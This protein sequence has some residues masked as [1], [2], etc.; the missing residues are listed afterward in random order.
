MAV[1]RLARRLRAERTDTSLS[2]SQIAALGTLARLGPMT[3]GEL[4]DVEKVQ[5]PSMTRTVAGARGS[6]PRPACPAPCRPASGAA[7]SDRGGRPDAA[8]RPPPPGRLAVSAHVGAHAGRPRQA[9]RRRRGPRTV[10]QLLSPTFSALRIRNYRLY[11]TGALISN[12]GTWMQR[13]AQ[14]WLVL[15]LTH[16]S[17]AALGITTGLQFLPI[18]LVTPFAGVVVDRVSKRKLL[19]VTQGFLGLTA[20]VARA[21]ST[22]PASSPSARSTSSR[23]SSASA[24]RSTRRLV[25]RSSW[26]WSDARTWPTP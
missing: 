18:L 1:M 2:L 7:D 5:P 9:A 23:C 11:I 16:G 14:D 8:R 12:T 21:S 25:R 24:L 3:P 15:Q 6:G 20:L 17:A 4:A 19:L 26:R 13:V 22:S 10:G